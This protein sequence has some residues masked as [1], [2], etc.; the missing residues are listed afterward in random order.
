[1]PY[2]RILSPCND[3]ITP[4]E[5]KGPWTCG[6]TK[7]LRGRYFGILRMPVQDAWLFL[8]FIP[9]CKSSDRFPFIKHDAVTVDELQEC[10]FGAMGH[11]IG[12]KIFFRLNKV[13]DPFLCNH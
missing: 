5:L 3:R 2:C 12:C 11:G 7:I 6:I 4:G 13:I 9:K 10:L 1:M 8:S